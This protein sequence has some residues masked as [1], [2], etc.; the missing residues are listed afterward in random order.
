MIER[1][2]VDYDYAPGVYD[3]SN[4]E[5]HSSPGI[6]RSGIMEFRKTPKHFW[7]K[8]LNPDY[9][10]KESTSDM[11]FGSAF[12]CYL[13]EPLKF[14]KEYFISQENPY[15]G[16]STDGRAFKSDMLS[17]S[18]GKILLS[19][20]DFSKIKEMAYSLT[21]DNR[22]A[23]LISN[24][25]YEK[26]IYWIDPDTQLLCKVRPDIWKDDF[27][28]DL[29]TTRNAS[30][31]EF[32]RDFYNFG[33]HLQLAMMHEAIKYNFKKEMTNFID[34]VIEKTE[35]YCHAI[36]FI[37]EKSITRGICEFKNIL[38]QIKDCFDNNKWPSYNDEILTLP[39]YAN[40]IGE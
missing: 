11:I 2:K 8:Y 17:K 18:K 20:D 26:S 21:S 38:M 10:K 32:Q 23:S 40:Q 15:H 14:E 36:Y 30:F 7:H 33:Y 22:S 25:K 3:I 5:Y 12:H 34:L 37:D 29:K 28:V 4:D 39:A 31:K 1:K 35:P 6:S 19:S 27:I 24:A 9:I 13:L 16:N